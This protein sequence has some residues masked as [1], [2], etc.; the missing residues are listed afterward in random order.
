MEA[1][2]SA[3]PV[4]KMGLS[5]NPTQKKTE[6]GGNTGAGVDC[7]RTCRGPEDESA[8]EGQRHA[9][10]A[11]HGRTGKKQRIKSGTPHSKRAD[12][13]GHSL[14]PIRQRQ[15]TRPDDQS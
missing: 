6:R 8:G 3:E 9:W 11:K 5:R 2:T 12:S 7:D 4:S 10:K 1:L 14:Q 13:L 15:M